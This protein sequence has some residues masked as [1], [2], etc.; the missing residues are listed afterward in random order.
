MNRESTRS[1]EKEPSG[2]AVEAEGV[3]DGEDTNHGASE[4]LGP[5]LEDEAHHFG[6]PH[7]DVKS[8]PTSHVVVVIKGLMVEADPVPD[9]CLVLLRDHLR[10]GD[11]IRVHPD[12]PR[13]R[14][15][16][17]HQIGEGHR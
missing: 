14:D 7:P 17:H 9:H 10:E 3:E 16:A 11:L 5:L 1:D 6:G 4:T 12:H 13:P 2:V 15:L 8:I